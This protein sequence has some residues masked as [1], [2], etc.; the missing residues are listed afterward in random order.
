MP[1]PCTG[2]Q[3]SNG[4]WIWNDPPRHESLPCRHKRCR[5]DPIDWC[6][7]LTHHPT[8]LQIC[9]HRDHTHAQKVRGRRHMCHHH[10]DKS[11]IQT[12][13]ECRILLDLVRLGCLFFSYGLCHLRHIWRSTHPTT[14]CPRGVSRTRCSAMPHWNLSETTCW[15]LSQGQATKKGQDV[16]VWKVRPAEQDR[17]CINT[18]VITSST[19][20]GGGGSFKKRKT[21]GEIGCCESRMSKQ[22]HWPTD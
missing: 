16:E 18:T 15:R 21:I 4:L 1:D 3:D 17:N 7:C 19:A 11:A 20:Q 5:D 9:P 10:H 12:H 13:L 22:K 8:D 14:L 6:A 2:F